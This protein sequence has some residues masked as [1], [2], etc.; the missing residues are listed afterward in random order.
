MKGREMPHPFT[1]LIEAPHALAAVPYEQRKADHD[2][3]MAAY[4]GTFDKRGFEEDTAGRARTFLETFFKS[5]Q[6]DCAG[7]GKFTRIDLKNGHCVDC[8]KERR[9]RNRLEAFRQ[10]VRC[11]TCSQIKRR[12]YLTENICRRCALIRKNDVARCV[13]CGKRS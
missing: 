5:V 6:G 13:D 10:K 7:C 8:Q 9:Q 2:L 1:V 3:V 12:A 11:E 4:L